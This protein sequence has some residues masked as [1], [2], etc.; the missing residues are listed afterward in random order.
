MTAAAQPLDGTQV[1]G[2]DCYDLGKWY[3][4]AE[5]GG[6]GLRLSGRALGDFYRGLVA[7]FPIATIEDP[8]DQ[9]QGGGKKST[10]SVGPP[11][12]V[13]SAHGTPFALCPPQDDWEN[14]EAFTA[15]MEGTG[16]QV[17]EDSASVFFS[18]RCIPP[19]SHSH[20]SPA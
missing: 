5:R 1:E 12:A 20:R 19:V 11:G 16:C 4:A 18:P 7:E 3:P 2:Q 10:G 8:F 13:G 14:W 9:V 6:L 17:G 15:A